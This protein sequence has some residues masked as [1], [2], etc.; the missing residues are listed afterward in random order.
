MRRVSGRWFRLS[1]RG[2]F[3]LTAFVGAFLAW[4]IRWVHE[5]RELLARHQSA[6]A[7]VFEKSWNGIYSDGAGYIVGCSFDRGPPDEPSLPWRL[8]VLG[9]KPLRRVRLTFF[10]GARNF[11][12]DEF[13][14]EDID[15]ALSL[16]PEAELTWRVYYTTPEVACS[17]IMPAIGAAGL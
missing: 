2:L 9:E 14:H 1:L 8:A 5:R 6:Q 11:D 10:E 16:F 13:H 3:L 12:T 17:A 4:Q 15:L 7:L